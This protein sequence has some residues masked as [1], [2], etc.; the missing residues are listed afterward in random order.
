MPSTN[1]KVARVLTSAPPSYA[2]IDLGTNSCRLLIAKKVD[3][4]LVVIDSFSDSVSLGEGINKTGEIN[5]KAKKRAISCLTK[6]KNKITKHN[7]VEVR[8]VA[9]EACR[10]ASNSDDFLNQIS[11][12]LNINFEIIDAREEAELAIHGCKDLY[13]SG[14]NV[15]FDIGGGSTQIILVKENN[16]IDFISIPYGVLTL[17]DKI[18]SYNVDEN[19]FD[20]QI[21][22]ISSYFTDLA[23]QTTE[24]INIIGTSGT[25]TT[26][27]STY[28]ELP[29]YDRNVI[30]GS[31][32]EQ[33][34]IMKLARKIAQMKIEDRDNIPSINKNYSKL[35]M[36]GCI[37]LYAIC[38]T[39]KSE[40]IN[41]ADRGI[42][43]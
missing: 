41:V 13:Q 26:I 42:R 6:I 12:D 37:I 3:D 27:T 31:V 5:E 28:L 10:R 16:I 40:H 9:T 35:M 38:D 8:A 7:V 20:N 32:V 17:T 4:E 21:K 11:K 29:T 25:I 30:D 15:I 1:N 14:M 2:V 33:E 22:Y 18:G 39:F 19:G 34:K 24:N 43:E 36:S 23:K